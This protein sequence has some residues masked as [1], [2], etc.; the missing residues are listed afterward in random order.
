[1]R[2]IEEVKHSNSL[3]IKKYNN[4]IIVIDTEFKEKVLKIQKNK[5]GLVTLNLY[6]ENIKDESIPIQT[7]AEVHERIGSY[8]PNYIQVPLIKGAKE[9]IDIR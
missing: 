6:N 4:C 2:K 8:L 5:S 7:M 3:K 1:M 9:I